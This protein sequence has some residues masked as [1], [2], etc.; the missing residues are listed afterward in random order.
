M[1]QPRP[2]IMIA[3]DNTALASA[4]ACK[5]ERVGFDTIVATDG[6]SALAAF[7]SNRVAAIVSDHHMPRMT[8]LELCRSVRQ[9]DSRIPFVLVSGHQE[10]ILASGVDRDLNILDIF[11]KP[12][13][14]TAVIASVQAAVMT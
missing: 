7:R 9:Q 1:F 6:E 2:L 3:D 11:G 10:E 4:L 14:V 12:F 8:G 13:N 5:F